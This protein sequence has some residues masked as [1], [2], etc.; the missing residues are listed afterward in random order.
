MT[1]SDSDSGSFS[2]SPFFRDQEIDGTQTGA[3][4][5]DSPCED[6]QRGAHSRQQRVDATA[7]DDSPASSSNSDRQHRIDRPAHRRSAGAGLGHYR[8]LQQI[9]KGGCG[10]VF[11]AEQTR[12]VRRKV[13]VK[14]IKPGLECAEA[15]GRF[16]A[17]TQ[18]M[19]VMDHP[20]IARVYDAGATRS[21]RPYFVMELI[22]GTPITLFCD[23]KNL[24]LRER[25]RL[26][27]QVC[28]AVHHAHQKGIIHRDVKPSNVLVTVRDGL[29]VVKVIDFGIAKAINRRLADNTG[30]TL[31]P[32]M[33]G[34]PLYMSPEQTDTSGIDIDTRT[35]IYSLGVLLYELLSGMTPFEKERLSKASDEEVRRIIRE[36]EPLLPSQR[37][38]IMGT[39]ATV[40]AARRKLDPRKLS[41]SLAGDLDWIVMKALEKDRVRRYDSAAALAAD[42]Q[43]HLRHEPVSAGPPS[44][45][46]QLRKFARRNKV[47]VAAVLFA[48]MAMVVAS[49]VSVL[50]TLALLNQLSQSEKR[51]ET[52]VEQA[53]ADKMQFA[54]Q[55]EQHGMHQ[56]AAHAYRALLARQSVELGPDHLDTLCTKVS[57]ARMLWHSD[58]LADA[59]KLAHQAF[60]GMGQQIGKDDLRYRDARH[61]FVETSS[62]RFL[63]LCGDGEEPPP[64]LDQAHEIAMWFADLDTLPTVTPYCLSWIEFHFGNPQIGLN[65]LTTNLRGG[66][67]TEGYFDLIAGLHSKLGNTEQTRD[68]AVAAFESAGMTS[69]WIAP[70]DNPLLKLALPLAAFEETPPPVDTDPRF[71]LEVYN[72]LI[73]EHPDADQLYCR[74]AHCHARLGD[75]RSAAA[76]FQTAFQLFPDDCRNQVYWGLAS[77][78]VGNI[79]G[80]QEACRLARNFWNFTLDPTEAA[81]SV[82]L[83]AI[84]PNSGVEMND[85]PS[86]VR[87]LPE[88]FDHQYLIRGLLLYRLGRSG[89]ALVT[90]QSV[91]MTGYERAL[92]ECLMAM[93]HFRNSNVESARARLFDARETVSRLLSAPSASDPWRGFDRPMME[94]MITCALRE[95]ESL[96]H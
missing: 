56:D 54:Y 94:A 45:W 41:A 3:P 25:L 78:M 30:F 69:H 33:L 86:I 75:W 72:R 47:A 21:G 17:E 63:Q 23:Q 92:C 87:S 90:L 74:R 81:A 42:V 55:L 44:T 66:R 58:E 1:R 80:Y 65:I 49:T 4:V 50:L 7:R 14:I 24:G 26:F 61:V 70:P 52:L 57:L 27:V 38:C 84:A 36:E 88:D 18:A 82:M 89:E 76:D 11:M 31:R 51:N 12:P 93:A 40:L 10:V 46:Y 62:R 2:D 43:R 96:I 68:W 64:D 73:A 53:L 85:L 83:C 22:K 13:A 20:N 5:V 71:Y 48:A 15:L 77:L 28:Q 39:S 95:A 91:S 8:L 29:P 32:H 34:S 37:L 59:A 60:R 19:A 35:D 67:V 9:G 79:D 16:A 6:D